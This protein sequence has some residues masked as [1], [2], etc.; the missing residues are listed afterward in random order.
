MAH[1]TRTARLWDCLARILL[2]KTC[3]ITFKPTEDS[4]KTVR[5]H[6]TNNILGIASCIIAWYWFILT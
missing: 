2:N 5:N 4:S 1:S 6:M 3:R